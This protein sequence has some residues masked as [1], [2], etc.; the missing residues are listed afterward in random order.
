MNVDKWP[1]HMGYMTHAPG[2]MAS[3]CGYTDAFKK[4]KIEN[5]TEILPFS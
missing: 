2:Y 5:Q 1:Q 4:V 3:T